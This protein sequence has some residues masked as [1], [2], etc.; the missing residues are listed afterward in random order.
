MI[1]PTPG[2]WWYDDESDIIVGTWGE[3]REPV[4]L[5]RVLF[6]EPVTEAE[7]IANGCLLAAAPELLAALEEAVALFRHYCFREGD[8]CGG[9]WLT[10]AKAAIAKAKGIND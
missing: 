7:A 4:W 2:P 5:A 9:P 10:A 8:T 1:Q 6:D 3:D